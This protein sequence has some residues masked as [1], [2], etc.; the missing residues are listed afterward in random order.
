MVHLF[1]ASDLISAELS[2]TKDDLSMEKI[3]ADKQRYISQ[4]WHSIIQYPDL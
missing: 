3:Q 2:H 4:E 1:V